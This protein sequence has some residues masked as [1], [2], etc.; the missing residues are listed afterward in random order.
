MEPEHKLDNDYISPKII[1]VFEEARTELIASGWKPS[2][3]DKINPVPSP[4][5]TPPT[6]KKVPG[7]AKPV[8]KSGAF[9]RSA[10]V[11]GLGQIYKGEKTKGYIFMGL[12]AIMTI[13]Y[14]GNKAN[15]QDAKDKYDSAKFLPSYEYDELW[16]EY[17]R[18]VKETNQ[19][20]TFLGIVWAV[21]VVDAGLIGW[22][23]VNLSVTA[24]SDKTM[25]NIS[26][27]F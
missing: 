2:D 15:Y 12:S 7:P 24:E 25:I 21:N 26:K 8:T 22:N 20:A 19:I 27:N 11:P 14:L 6:V 18:K 13:G 10:F 16:K 3:K 4:M 23:K 17:E 1:A 5:P 9:L